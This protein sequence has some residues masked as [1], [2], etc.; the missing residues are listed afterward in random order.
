MS[1]LDRHVSHVQ[2]RLAMSRFVVVLAWSVLIAGCAATLAVILWRMTGHTQLPPVKWWLLAGAVPVIASAMIAFTQRPGAHEAAVA[3]DDTLNLKEKFSTALSMRPSKDPFA[4]AAVRDAEAT[5]DNVQLQRQFPIR[6]PRIGYGALATLAMAISVGL[7][8]KP[9]DLFGRPAADKKKAE[10][11]EQQIVDAKHKAQEALVLAES[12]PNNMTEDP[13][14]T[15]DAKVLRDLI[16]N[17]KFDDPSHVS[18]TAQK[19]LEDVQQTLADEASKVDHIAREQEKTF[20][21]TFGNASDYKSDPVK[22]VDN[23]LAS[24]QF[25][26]AVDH[27]QDMTDKFEKMTA[28]EKEQVA[29]DVAKLADKLK[30]ASEDPKVQKDVEDKLKQMGVNPAQAA[31]M[32]KQMQQAAQGDKKAQQALANQVQ[33]MQQQMQQQAQQLQKQAAQGN[34]QAQQQLAQLQQQQ[35]AVQ[36]AVQGMQGQANAQAQQ[37]QMAQAASQ[38]AQAMQAQAQA[39]QKGQQGQQGK[40]TSGQQM[41]QAQGQMQQAMQGMQAARAD[42]KQVAAAQQQAMKQGGQGKGKGKDGQGNDGKGQ[43]K[44]GQGKDGQGKDGQGDQPGENGGGQDGQAKQGGQQANPVPGGDPGEWKAG[45]PN[46]NKGGNQMGG[47]GIANGGQDRRKT[48]SGF[49]IKTETDT[50][51]ENEK[52]K[53]LANTMIKDNQP[54]KGESKLGLAQVTESVQKQAADEVDE[55]RVSGPSRKAAEDYFRTMNRDAVKK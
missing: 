12:L 44:S 15:A 17:Q 45:D 16:R 36:K 32:A 9:M 55:D 29:K 27:L 54:V 18:R 38:M 2:N 31:A 25:D 51:V 1:R 33:Q 3:I 50:G 37:Q 4:Q 6:F 53:I 13:K 8:M 39:G 42:A 20:A 26:K 35:Q 34:Q 5:A 49:D 14:L 41:A 7:W 52:G 19:V 46:K 11:L 10:L 30:N 22:K 24:N 23:D 21:E 48:P 43:G 28:Q 47:A 40:S